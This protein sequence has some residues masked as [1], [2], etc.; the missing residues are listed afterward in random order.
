MQETRQPVLEEAPLGLDLTTIGSLKCC[1]N[2]QNPSK[3]VLE[4]MIISDD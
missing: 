4:L 3:N 2:D 1:S